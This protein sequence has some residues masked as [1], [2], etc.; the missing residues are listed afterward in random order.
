MGNAVVKEIAPEAGIGEKKKRGNIS[1]A[2]RTSTAAMLIAANCRIP[3]AR[4]TCRRWRCRPSRGRFNGTA[5]FPNLKSLFKLA[6]TCACQHCV[7]SIARQLT[8]WNIE[9]SHKRRVTIPR[10][11]RYAKVELFKR[12]P[13]LG[14]IDLG[15]KMPIRRFPYR[16]RL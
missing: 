10:A 12:R 14:E 15:V 11:S 13:G 8:S 9:F 7:L 6:D 1:K 16:P 3:C 5:D 2:E 4:W